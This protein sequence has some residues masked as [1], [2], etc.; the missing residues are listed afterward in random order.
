MLLSSV[1]ALLIFISVLKL[2]DAHTSFLVHEIP[3]GE[4]I[5][6]EPLK[7]E[8]E[9]YRRAL[10]QWIELA[11][12]WSDYVADQQGNRIYS[13]EKTEAYVQPILRSMG[14]TVRE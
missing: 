3:T 6:T 12:P 14:L 4:M 2:L 9:S 5:I 10:A 8:T 7:N 1:V 11:E 13:R